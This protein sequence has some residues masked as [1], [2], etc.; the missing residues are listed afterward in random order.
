[1]ALLGYVHRFIREA[2]TGSDLSDTST[3]RRTSTAPQ[4]NRSSH[5]SLHAPPVR[6]GIHRPLLRLLHPEL[7]PRR[8]E[9]AA[10]LQ[11]ETG[12]QTPATFF[13]FKE[14]TFSFVIFTSRIDRLNVCQIRECSLCVKC[15]K[16]KIDIMMVKRRFQ[17]NA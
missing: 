11:P 10:G 4:K 15:N 16:E 3:R 2:S 8:Q 9:S 5:V 17:L 12:E 1:M 7:P 14:F 6:P 13:F